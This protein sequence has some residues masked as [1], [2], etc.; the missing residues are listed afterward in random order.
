[1][2][3][4]RAFG[5]AACLVATSSAAQQPKTPTFGV[6]TKVVLVDLVVTDGKD[7]VVTGLSAA[8][9]IIKEDGKV[10][11]IVS[12]AAFSN[13]TTN[14]AGPQD[15]VVEPFPSATPEPRKI[16]NAIA[17]LFVDDGQLSPVQAMRMRPALKKLV[18]SLA[19]RNGALA[20]VAPWANISLANEVEGNRALFGAAIDKIKGRRFEERGTEPMADAEALAIERGDQSMLQRLSLRFVA[21]NPGLDPDQ[22]TAM[23]RSR[24]MEVARDARNRRKDAFGVLLK[25]LDWLIKQPGR[26]SVVMVSGGFAADYEDDEQREVVT[27]SHDAKAPIHFLDARGLQGMGMFQGVEYGPAMDREA[28]ETPFAFAEAAEGSTSLALDTGGLVVRNTNNFEKGLER[29]FDTMSTYYVLGYDP[30]EH[31]KPGFRKIKVE[32]KRKGLKVIA[33]RGYFDKGTG[34]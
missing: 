30:P 34:S 10:R 20:L 31:A 14:A 5:I 15:V 25:S 19:E 32:I 22:A 21:L 2:I 17:V 3:R 27:R 12:F 16:P 28:G 4:L 11:P 13:E 8:D 1:M 29:L 33:R 23:V 26:H 18:D 6:G 9:F 7:N 24:A